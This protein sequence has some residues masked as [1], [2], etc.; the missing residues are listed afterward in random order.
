MGN[1]LA[2]VMVTLASAQARIGRLV[3]FELPPRSMLLYPPVM[4]MMREFRFEA[5]QRDACVDGAPWRKPLLVLT[6]T[7]KVG[8]ALCATCPGGHK[9]VV[10]R[11]PA[12]QG[13]PW[14]RVAAPYW[15]A[16]CCAIVRA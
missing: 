16:W 2:D 3:H 15:P 12:P 7:V 11:G 13:I 4:S 5:Y 6:P 10:L 1:A 14:T 8:L 9:H